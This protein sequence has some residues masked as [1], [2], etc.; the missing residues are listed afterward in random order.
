M[1]RERKRRDIQQKEWIKK[2]R[3]TE[4][5][6]GKQSHT[7][8]IDV[9]K[10]QGNISKKEWNKNVMRYRQVQELNRD[11]KRRIYIIDRKRQDIYIGE[12]K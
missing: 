5:L 1:Y 9:R 7:K 4:Y 3:V 12:T 11:K 8:Y 6:Q 10:G 2:Y